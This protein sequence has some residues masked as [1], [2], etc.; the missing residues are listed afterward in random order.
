MSP[1]W[2]PSPGFQGRNV[3]VTA[4]HSE[5]LLTQG[6]CHVHTRSRGWAG[7]PQQWGLALTSFAPSPP[8]LWPPSMTEQSRGWNA[9]CIPLPGPSNLAPRLFPTF[10]HVAAGLRSVLH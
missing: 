3:I 1:A 6:P 7:T 10:S 5:T 4:E 8:L 2:C 9:P